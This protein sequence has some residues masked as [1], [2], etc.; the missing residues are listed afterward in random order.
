MADQD[1]DSVTKVGSKV[2][3]GGVARETVVRGKSAINAAQRT[4]SVIGTEK[5][6]QSGNAVCKQPVAKPR[7]V[8]LTVLTLPYS[9]A[10]PLSKA[11]A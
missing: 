3:G 2:R 10:S 5:K 8:D 9:P 7:S 4:G 6:F 1:W 11:S